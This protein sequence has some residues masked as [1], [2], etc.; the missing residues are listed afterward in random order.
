MG[1]L[2]WY[3]NPLLT[4][5]GR[6]HKQD[7]TGETEIEAISAVGYG[8]LGLGQTPW[9]QLDIYPG[10]RLTFFALPTHLLS[11]LKFPTG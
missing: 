1:D 4:Q 7:P 8:E 3:L 11:C 2:S 9:S 10:G 6:R 5:Q